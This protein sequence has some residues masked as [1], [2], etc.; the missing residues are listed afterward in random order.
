MTDNFKFQNDI[1]TYLITARYAFTY[2]KIPT[3]SRAKFPN[4]VNKLT[5]NL[6]N[7]HENTERPI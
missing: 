6:Q 4:P 1:S 5:P 3:K 7:P 2:H